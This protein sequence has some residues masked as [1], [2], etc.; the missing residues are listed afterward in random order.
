MNQSACDVILFTDGACQGNPG[1]GGW[2]VVMRSGVHEKHLS[3]YVPHTT[4]NRMEMQAVLEGLTAIKAP[5]RVHVVVDSQYV[6]QGI[7]TWM[8]N[9]K[10]KDWKTAQGKP[11]KNKD[12]W[13]ALDEAVIR[14][15]EVVFFWV[16]GHSG[17]PENDKADALAVQAIERRK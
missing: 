13:Q 9:W 3:G 5:S 8:P 6:Q 10:K 11:V 4:N 12:L 2:G 17:H 15:Q 14:H 1:P 16:K 7:M